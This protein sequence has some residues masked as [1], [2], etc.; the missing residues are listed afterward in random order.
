MV[1]TAPGMTPRDVY[2]FNAGFIGLNATSLNATNWAAY[3]RP[4][5]WQ[6]R[7]L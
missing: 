5:S 1:L 7:I 6:Y 4:N 2:L 3:D